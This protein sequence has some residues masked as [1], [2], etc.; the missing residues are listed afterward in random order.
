ME[1]LLQFF[2]TGKYRVGFFDQIYTIFIL[3]ILYIFLYVIGAKKCV[4]LKLGGI[5]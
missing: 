3:I 4:L 2:F 1:M 5:V